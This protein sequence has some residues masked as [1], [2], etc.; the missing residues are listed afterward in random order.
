MKSDST[1]YP[2]RSPLWELLNEQAPEHAEFFLL[3]KDAFGA[4]FIDITFDREI[5]IKDE[6]REMRGRRFALRFEEGGG[7]IRGAK[8]SSDGWRDQG[9]PGTPPVRYGR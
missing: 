2:G 5:T 9:P 4:K 3:C 6:E 8:T 7:Q 1:V